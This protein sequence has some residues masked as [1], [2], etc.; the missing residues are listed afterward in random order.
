MSV[1]RA[2]FTPRGFLITGGIVLL[3][4]G[5]LGF[6]I[7]NNPSNTFFWL[8]TGENYAH[9]TLGVTALAAATVPGLRST[10]A[11]Y[12]RWLVLLVGFLAL[13]FVMYG[14]LLPP[15]GPGAL[16][17]FGLANLEFGDTL[18]HLLVAIWA[19][20]AAY[21]TPEPSAPPA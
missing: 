10:M 20:I 12:Y 1:R 14:F 15:G 18:L 2:L 7:L 19:F 5:L 13:F 8:T 11:P 9:V 21:W 16:N 17:T 4:L 6:F 3:V